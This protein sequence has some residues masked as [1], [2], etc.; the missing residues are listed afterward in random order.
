MSASK[1]NG[2]SP[3]KKFFTIMLAVITPTMVQG[4]YSEDYCNAKQSTV[5]NFIN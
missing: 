2:K 1:N 5:P 3:F 4:Y